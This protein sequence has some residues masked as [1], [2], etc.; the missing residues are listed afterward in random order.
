[1]DGFGNHI[2]GGASFISFCLELTQ[3]INTSNSPYTNLTLFDPALAPRPG[4]NL[5]PPTAGP[6]DSPMGA[7][8]ALALG[9][10]WRE[11]FDNALASPINE[12]A[13]Q[14]AIWKI[15]Y[16]EADD[17]ASW[18]LAVG[19]FQSNNASSV[20][21]IAQGYLN[22]VRDHHATA[23]ASNLRAMSQFSTPANPLSTPLAFQDQLV[24][25]VPEPASLI[26][27]SALALIGLCYGGWRRRATGMF[28]RAEV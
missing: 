14:L 2:G 12:A 13:F 23:P 18:N 7:S 5:P 6:E 4:S 11:F 1:V 10:L 19:N 9:Q 8:A 27:W 22:W 25:V 20:G 17:L 16:D 28:T 24:E 26:A 15:E 3:G 21:L